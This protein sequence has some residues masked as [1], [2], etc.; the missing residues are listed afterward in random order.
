MLPSLRIA[1]WSATN[2]WPSFVV[3]VCYCL[4][5][6]RSELCSVWWIVSQKPFERKLE[7]QIEQF[8]ANLMK[9][10]PIVIVC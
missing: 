1:V 4:N 5:H 10:L 6:N 9:C 8:H 2:S 7:N 3:I